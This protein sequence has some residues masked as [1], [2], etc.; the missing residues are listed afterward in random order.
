MADL[1]TLTTPVPVDHGL[2]TWQVPEGWNQGRGAFGGLVL[3]TMVR[4]AS[5]GVTDGLR[6]R[7]LTATLCGPTMVGPSDIQVE[8]L[9]VGTGTH[10]IEVRLLQGGEL[11]VQATCIF[12][13]SRVRDGTWDDVTMPDL[14]NWKHLEV[15]PVVPPLAPMFAQNMHFRPILGFP[16]TPGQPR[17]T[18]G[19]VRVAEPGPVRGAAYLVA[20][21]DAWWP[22][23]LLAATA[24]RPIATVSFTLD[25]VGELDGLDPDAPFLHEATCEQARDG[26]LVEHRTL[27]GEDGR[28]LA[29][30]TQT[31]VMIR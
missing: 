3:A 20:H 2:F 22:V 1:L 27:R 11:R 24:P 4:A 31:F 13:R 16:F 23:A 6:L 9:R 21:A 12:G 25:I 26:Y 28:V 10:V 14:P 19:W 5:V 30:N 17:R 8:A 29:L 18:L 15:A 7:T